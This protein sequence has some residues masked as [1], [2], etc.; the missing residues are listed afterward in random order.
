M[1]LFVL[2]LG[3]LMTA[4]AFGVADNCMTQKNNIDRKYC[5]DKYLE[6]VKDKMKAEKKTWGT[7]LTQTDKETKVEATEMELQAKKDY[8]SMMQNEISLT[9]KHLQ[10]LNSAQVA[11]AAAAPAKKEKKKKEK[12]KL[13][14][15]KL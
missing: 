13:F 4:S 6:T 9:E 12:K 2:A 3:T 10:E 5:M 1:K 14:G 8:L 11:V 7:G 15:I